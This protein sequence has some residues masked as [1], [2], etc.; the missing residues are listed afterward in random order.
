[1]ALV[2]NNDMLADAGIDAA[3]LGDLTW[4]PQDGGT[5]EELIAALSIDKNGVRG[6]EDGFDGPTS[7][8]TGSAS[9]APVV[10]SVRPS[11][12]GSPSP[13]GSPT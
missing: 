2:V 1:M 5:F 3:T 11:G 10:A 4:N 8:P 12:A 13:T 9:S 6:N 7:P